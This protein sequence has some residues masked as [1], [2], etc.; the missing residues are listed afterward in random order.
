MTEEE[1]YDMLLFSGLKISTFKLVHFFNMPPGN[2]RY[3]I[4]SMQVKPEIIEQLDS[5]IRFLQRSEGDL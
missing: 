1:A 3:I 2:K 5:A 4:C